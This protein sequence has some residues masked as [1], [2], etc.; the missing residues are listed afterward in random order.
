MGNRKIVLDAN[1][2]VRA[3]LGHKVSDLMQ[4]SC[5]QNDFY[6]PAMCF[7]EVEKHLPTICQKRSMA[8]SEPLAAMDKLKDA[9]TAVESEAYSFYEQEAK[10]R[11]EVRDINDWPVVACALLLNCPIWTEDND[12]FG[13]GL[14]TWTTDRVHLYLLGP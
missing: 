1:I 6:T 2:I 5:S 12:F 14:P 4:R 9:I 8:L 7:G 11:I 13:T 10:S 3:I